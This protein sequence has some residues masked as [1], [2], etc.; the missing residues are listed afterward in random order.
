[1]SLKKL[2]QKRKNL[3]DELYDLHHAEPNQA[4]YIQKRNEIEHEIACLEEAIELEKRMAPFKWV[5]YAFVVIISVM[6][7]Y[8]CIM[9]K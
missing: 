7:V 3:F 8:A 6:F 4:M 1:M 2:E 9:I 5:L